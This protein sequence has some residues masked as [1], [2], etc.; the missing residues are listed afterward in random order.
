[1]DGTCDASAL[2][3]IERELGIRLPTE[4]WNG[5]AADDRLVVAGPR[6]G[7]EI[8]LYP[9]PELSGINAAAELPSRLPGLGIIGTDGSREM[10]AIDGRSEPSPVVLVDVAFSRWDD[11]IWQAPDLATF[12]QEYPKRGLRWS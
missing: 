3:G 7:E 10:L 11:A 9:V 2:T 1:M 4:Y 5:L 6:P 12:L 8:W